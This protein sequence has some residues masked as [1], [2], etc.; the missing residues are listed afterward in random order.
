MARPRKTDAEAGNGEK[1]SKA[2]M[3]RKAAQDIGGAVRPRDIIAALKEKGVEVSSAQV[4]TTL[5]AAGFRRKRRRKGGAAAATT[6]HASNGG[7]LNV[8]ALVAAKA[9]ISKVGSLEVA[10]EAIRA[11]KRLQ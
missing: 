8:D 3:I 7:G 1:T 2:A 6:S 9:L 10:E 4:S 5:A 11:L